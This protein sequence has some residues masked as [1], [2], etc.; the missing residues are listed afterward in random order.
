MKN[1]Y[2]LFI[3]ILCFSACKK[4]ELVLDGESNFECLEGNLELIKDN[5]CCDAEKNSQICEVLDAKEI[6]FIASKTY[7]LL[8]NACDEIG[9]IFTFSSGSDQTEFLITAKKHF[10]RHEEVFT[11]CN[12]EMEMGT[13]IFQKNE[14]LYI[15]ALNPLF[16]NDTI[17][18]ELRSI[19][20]NYD[21]QTPGPKEDWFWIQQPDAES[22]AY[23]FSYIYKP[24]EQVQ[25]SLAKGFHPNIVLNG[26]SFESVT[27]FK[28]AVTVRAEPHT[29]FYVNDDSGWFAFERNGRVWVKD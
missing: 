23:N 5:D 28:L 9:D 7:D 21:E 13:Y 18:L 2:Q 24:G 12:G 11:S 14:I 6:N 1:I 8:P 4:Q 27:E 25:N 10:I 19:I 17:H 22:I 29:R 16:G 15:E 20:I 26:Q 3:L